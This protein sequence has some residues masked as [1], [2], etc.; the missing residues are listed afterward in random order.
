MPPDA[1][2]SAPV[3]AT[4]SATASAP[5]RATSDR[6]GAQGLRAAGAPRKLVALARHVDLGR[7]RALDVGCGEGTY[8][9]HFSPASVGLDRDPA[10]VAALRAA[11]LDARPCDVEAPGWQRGLG[12]FDLV[13]L[14]DLLVHLRDPGAFLR[15]SA[16]LLAPG[17]RVVVV[18]WL[19]PAGRARAAAL[20][21]IV[22]GGRATLEEPEHLHRFTRP[23]LRA[24]LAGAG[25]AVEREECHSFASPLGRAL[26]GSWW[27]PRTLIARRAG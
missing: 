14:C 8:L 9:R 6:A 5:V 18:E 20:A 26:A 1:R 19:W 13:W 2:A 3:R 22:P 17:G 21:R 24:L 15:A 4:S 7:A 25:L 12:A 16:P 23:A 27:P 10:R 11:G